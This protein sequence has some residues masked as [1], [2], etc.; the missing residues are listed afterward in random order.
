MRD[1]AVCRDGV[2]TGYAPSRTGRGSMAQSADLIET[3]CRVFGVTRDELLGPS[4]ERRIAYAR[5][6]CAWAIHKSDP[7]RS[8]RAIGEVLGGRHHTTILNAI[9]RAEELAHHD[10]DYARQLAELWP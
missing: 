6:A 9:A 7:T 4:R 1:T 2:M 5:F 3:T 10:Q 8:Y